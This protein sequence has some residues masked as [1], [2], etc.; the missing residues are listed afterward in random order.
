M[1]K[2]RA[3]QFCGRRFTLRRAMV[4]DWKHFRTTGKWIKTPTGPLPCPDV[5]ILTHENHCARDLIYE[6]YGAL[7]PLEKW[8]KTRTATRKD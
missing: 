7:N 8:V 5:T 3:C 6:Q 1:T 4:W 2:T